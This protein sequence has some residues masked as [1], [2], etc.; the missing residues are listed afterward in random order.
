MT[1]SGT[2]GRRPPSLQQGRRGEALT[3]VRRAR[4]A[5]AEL[6]LEPT[7]PLLDLERSIVA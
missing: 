1:T 4:S 2:C 6:G 5:L 3:V 7:R